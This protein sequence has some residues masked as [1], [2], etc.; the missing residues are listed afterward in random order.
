MRRKRKSEILTVW[1]TYL[2]F[3]CILAK[4]YVMGII[5]NRNSELA[6]RVYHYY[7]ITSTVAPHL[8]TTPTPPHQEKTVSNSKDL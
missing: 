8:E 2:I 4:F 1:I 5:R 6:Y 7:N 3:K